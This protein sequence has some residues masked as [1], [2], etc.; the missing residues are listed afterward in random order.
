MGREITGDGLGAKS[1]AIPLRART[2]C[3]TRCS[4]TELR[5]VF[6][7]AMLH[8]SETGTALRDALCG[9]NCNAM[10]SHSIQEARD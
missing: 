9:N 8:I 7:Y 6:V 3:F 5:F 1:I 4:K 2:L 10:L